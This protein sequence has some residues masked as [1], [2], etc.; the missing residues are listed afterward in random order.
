MVGVAGKDDP[1]R[2]KEIL[3]VRLHL[4]TG[5]G[6]TPRWR[7]P[8]G[9]G[10]RGRVWWKSMVQHRTE[11]KR[12]AVRRIVLGKPAYRGEAQSPMVGRP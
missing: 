12:S 7:C 3:P 8:E 10:P 6:S 5:M 11:R 4:R 9:G 1:W 2:A